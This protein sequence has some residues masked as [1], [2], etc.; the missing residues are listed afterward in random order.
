MEQINNTNNP[1]KEKHV[2]VVRHFDDIDDLEI[3]GRDPILLEGQEKEAEAVADLLLTQI[4]ERGKKAV[5][6]VTSPRIRAR[7]TA[8]IVIDVLH[9]KDSAL[10]CVSVEENDLRA[11]DQGKFILP[12]G[13]VSGQEFKGL[14]L[15]DQ[16]FFEETHASE[17]NGRD[18]NYD[19]RYG[20]P[21]LLKNNQFQYPELA[22]FFTQSGESYR[23]VLVRLYNLV[24]TLS[25]KAHKLEKNTELVLITHGQPGQI[26]KDLKKV[27]ELIKNKEIEYEQGKLAK[28]CWEI[29][30]KRDVSKKATGIAEVISVEEL[31]DPYL[32][33]LLK[34]ELSF[35][36]R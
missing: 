21:V 26:F 35:L 6:F 13:Y 8:S 19:Y 27:A 14:S 24:I 32:I 33:G 23:D 18:D 34:Q 16:I 5:L 15:A 20:D 25:Q 36:K 11:I 29:Y 31:A 30:K 12:P 17:V 1:S 28:M 10:R 7:Q 22:K 9:K 4:K 3:Y 2:I